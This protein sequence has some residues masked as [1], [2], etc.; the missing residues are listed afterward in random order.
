[1]RQGTGVL[2]IEDLAVGYNP[3]RSTPSG[4]VDI[5]YTVVMLA[6]ITLLALGDGPT[7]AMCL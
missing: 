6:K 4:P 1:M 3:K 7:R 2:Y 5:S